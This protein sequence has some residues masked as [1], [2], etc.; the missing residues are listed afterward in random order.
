M[1]SQTTLANLS[2]VNAPRRYARWKELMYERVCASRAPM[3]CFLY[4]GLSDEDM[5]F[6]GIEVNQKSVTMIPESFTSATF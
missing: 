1:I 4:V 3:P 6:G 2:V 5:N